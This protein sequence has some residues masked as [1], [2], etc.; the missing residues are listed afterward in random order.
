MV[1]AFISKTGNYIE[2][3]QRVQWVPSFYLGSGAVETATA[4][5]PL[6]IESGETRLWPIHSIGIALGSCKRTDSTPFPAWTWPSRIL[7]QMNRL[8]AARLHRTTR[9][10]DEVVSVRHHSPH[11]LRKKTRLLESKPI[12]L[13]RVSV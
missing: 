2:N 11:A 13:W 9:T 3:R 5:R 4:A 10:P 1:D 6:A 7:L 8:T 12:N